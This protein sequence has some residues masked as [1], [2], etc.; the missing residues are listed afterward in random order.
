MLALKWFSSNESKGG[1]NTLF[2]GDTFHPSLF[3]LASIFFGFLLPTA[4]CNETLF[5]TLYEALLKY[6][7][8]LFGVEKLRHNK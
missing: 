6:C 1:G 2:R 3:N 8:Q 4:S 7:L 5:V